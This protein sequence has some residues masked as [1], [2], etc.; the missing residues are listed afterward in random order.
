MEVLR[1]GYRAFMGLVVCLALSIMVQS[2]FAGKRTQTSINEVFVDYDSN[3]IVISGN[4]FAPRRKGGLAVVLGDPVG[5]FGD[6][7]EACVLDATATPQTIECILPD[8]LPPDG[9]YLLTVSIGTGK[10]KNDEY[11]LTID[12]IGRQGSRNETASPKITDQRVDC[13]DAAQGLLRWDGTQLEFCTGDGWAE[14]LLGAPKKCCNP[15]EEPG[16]NGNPPCLEGSACCPNTGTWTCSIGDG[17]TFNCGG[18]LIEQPQG[19]A[20]INPPPLACTDDVKQCPDGSFV[21]RDPKNDCEFAACPPDCSA[22]L[23]LKPSCNTGEIL[24]TPPG[25][26]CPVCTVLKNSLTSHL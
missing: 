18:E 8:G 16:V 19:K 1:V 5:G 12:S 6:I 21:A 9:D 22:V 2:A 3:S 25:E 13:D 20:C 26:C 7:T 24:V 15:L 11:D 10:T 17:V 14:V 23:C 4:G